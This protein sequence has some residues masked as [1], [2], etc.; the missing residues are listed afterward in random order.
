MG[1]TKKAIK[2]I[3]WTAFL[4][5]IVKSVGFVEM[6]ILARILIPR[7]FGA[8]GVAMLMLG[9]LEV[10]TESGVNVILVQEEDIDKYINSAWIVSIFRGAL[11]SLIIFFSAPIVANFF[12]SADS[13]ILLY[14][15]SIVPLLRGFL[16]P[17]IVKFQ[18]ELR[19]QR[20][21]LFQF[22]G[23]LIDTFV[24]ITTCYLMRSPIGIVL[25]LIAGVI[26]ELV[27]SF[28]VAS[29]RPRLELERAYIYKLSHRG[30]WVTASGVFNFL[31]HN[32]DNIVVGRMLGTSA[33]GVYQIAY[34]LSI[35]P[36]TEVA[37]VFSR[38]TFP[39]F[40]KISSD[41]HRLWIAFIKIILVTTLLTV[42]FGVLL[43]VF[44]QEIITIT[45]GKK[46]L[47]AIAILPTLAIF[48]VLRAISGS[49]SALFLAVGKQEYV[50]FVTLVSLV[51]LIIPIIPLVLHFGILGAAMSALAGSVIA[52]PVMIY[53][54]WKVF[55]KVHEKS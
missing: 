25:G 51:G 15:I 47:A 36:I 31:F 48:G 22:P 30:K 9:L 43:Y 54:T 23:I 8:F 17:S 38:V 49:S 18:K 50:T 46:W 26:V 27:L 32:A 2:G 42:P 29:P 52:L 20:D 33:L 16:N 44:P 7:Q 6:L 4:R 53:G 13:L 37:D 24:S 19:F 34:S 40:A 55:S 39:V 11:I 41:T 21:F 14:L 3:S 12:H 10:I 5:L 45:L 35:I 28:F 1:Y